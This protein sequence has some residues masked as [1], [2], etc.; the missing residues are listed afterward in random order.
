MS[1][2]IN[3][4]HIRDAFYKTTVCPGLLSHLLSNSPE[5]SL[6]VNSRNNHDI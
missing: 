1:Y 5:S 2:Q 6:R 4:L 3:I